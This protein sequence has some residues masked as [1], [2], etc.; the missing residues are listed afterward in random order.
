MGNRSH[1]Q[2]TPKDI[3]GI[4][5]VSGNAHGRGVLKVYPPG[6]RWALFPEHFHTDGPPLHIKIP[7]NEKFQAYPSFMIGQKVM[8]ERKKNV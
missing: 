3:K 8:T 6:F 4:C 7:Q 2:A 1:A 5:K